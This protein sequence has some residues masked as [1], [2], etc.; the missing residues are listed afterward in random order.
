MADKRDYY[1]V[2]GV[3][4][5]ADD[6]S[7]KKAY[8][9]L[10]KKYHPDMNPD[11]KEA[12]AKFKEVN[13]AYDVLSDSDKRAKYDQYGHAAFD[14]AS[15]GGGYGGGFGGFGDFGD[16]GDIFG[17][18]FGGGFGGGSS[19]RANAPTRG[20]DVSARVNISF[21]EAVF[22]V[23]RD[24]SFAKIQK[25]PDCSGS[26][27]KKGTQPETC[28]A[29]G[30]TGQ[31]RITQRLGGMAFQSTTTCNECR[32]SGKTVKDPCQNCRGT[33]Y[34]KVNKKLSVSIPAGIDDGER[35]ALRAQGC[36][37]RNGGPAGDLIITVN[38]KP[39]AIFERDGY[40]LYCEVPITV[41]E[42]TLGAEIDVP[43]LE[44]NQKFTIPEGTQPNTRFTLR[45]KGVPY[46]N[47]SGRRGDIIFTVNIEIP[48][49]LNEK[50]REKMREFADAC[51]ENNYSKKTGFF[52]RMFDK[53]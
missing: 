42:A 25:C 32:G 9:A 13:E 5:D 39:H 40:N 11:N 7:I 34:I 17:S 53:K 12:E 27:A 26:G 16:I 1:E 19:R 15:A 49:G 41:A 3:S 28:K 4:K 47:N 24:V 30:G 8:R 10:A 14:P 18:F 52:K 35:I 45:Q 36:D 6:A 21:E 37:G 44:G 51:G 20:E 50:Q 31:K 22:G 46:V 43:T 33:G 23:K 29:C 38:V 48:K 2:L